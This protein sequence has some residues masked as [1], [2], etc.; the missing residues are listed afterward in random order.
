MDRSYRSAEEEGE[1]NEEEGEAESD[2]DMMRLRIEIGSN[3]R[4]NCRN[5][6]ESE[7]SASEEFSQDFR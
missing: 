4:I 7:E 1:E 3:R 2:D 6:K 5:D